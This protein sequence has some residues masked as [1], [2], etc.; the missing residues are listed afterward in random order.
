MSAVLG[1]ENGLVALTSYITVEAEAGDCGRA[2]SV[3][4]LCRWA[5]KKAHDIP[6]LLLGQG[7][8]RRHTRAR[9]AVADEPEQ[10]PRLRLADAFGIERGSRSHTL[11]AIAVALRTIVSVCLLTSR[12]RSS[13]LSVR[14]FR[15]GRRR[16]RIAEGSLLRRCKDAAK[17]NC[18][19]YKS[20]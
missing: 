6:A 12:Y 14:I 13:A 5:L 20:G 7:L 16:R 4:L 19:R 10:R 11:P 2:S 3:Y 18:D 17:R 9:L 1:A 8:P 15:R